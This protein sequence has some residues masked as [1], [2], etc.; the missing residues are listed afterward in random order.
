MRRNYDAV[1]ALSAQVKVARPPTDARARRTHA[2]GPGTR[3][4]RGRRSRSAPTR[5]PEAP[6]PRGGFSPACS[7]ICCSTSSTIARTSRLLD[8][9]VITK[10]STI[11]MIRRRRERGCPRPSSRRPPRP[12]SAL[13]F[14]R[15]RAS[16]PGSGPAGIRSH[17]SLLRPHCHQSVTGRGAAVTLCGRTGRGMVRVPRPAGQRGSPR[18]GHDPS[19]MGASRAQ[20]RLTPPVPGAQIPRRRRDEEV[21][22]FPGGNPVC[23][24]RPK[25]AQRG[26]DPR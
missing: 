14:R 8:P 6:R 19:P 15:R 24:G 3:A 12:R 2:S 25:R 7:K 11:P 4:R 21:D 22:R 13:S 1:V 18:L 17:A 10:H 23:A 5:R 9:L 16:R 20:R 26:R